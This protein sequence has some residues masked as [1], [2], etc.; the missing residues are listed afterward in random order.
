MKFLLKR[1]LEYEVQY[2]TQKDVEKVKWKAQ[3]I[4]EWLGK[5]EESES[6]KN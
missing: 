5:V 4:V 2:G 6:E 3:D 1:Y